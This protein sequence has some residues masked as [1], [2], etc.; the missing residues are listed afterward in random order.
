MNTRKTML[1]LM[2]NLSSPNFVS[3]QITI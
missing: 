2:Q 1:F 3:Q